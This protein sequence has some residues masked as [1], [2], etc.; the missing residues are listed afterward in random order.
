MQTWSEVF[1]DAADEGFMASNYAAY[2]E[3][4]ARAGKS[5]YALPIHVNV[6]SCTPSSRNGAIS[7]YQGTRPYVLW[8]GVNFE[9]SGASLVYCTF[10]VHFA[11]RRDVVMHG[12]TLARR[13]GVSRGWQ[14]NPNTL[15]WLLGSVSAAR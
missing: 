3:A 9:C 11:N 2:I 13:C 4:I 8:P 10:F 14:R 7:Q 5:E 6:C 15:D 1:E 12:C